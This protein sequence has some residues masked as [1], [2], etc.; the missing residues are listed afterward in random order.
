MLMRA[1]LTVVAGVV[2]LTRMVVGMGHVCDALSG[3]GSEDRA[4]GRAG[5]NGD[6]IV[7]LLVIAIYIKGLIYPVASGPLAGSGRLSSAICTRGVARSAKGGQPSRFGGGL[8]KRCRTRTSHQGRQIRL[9]ACESIGGDEQRG[10][11]VR[12]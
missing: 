8:G 1:A 3:R 11:F 10:I 9:A 2:V 12:E 7:R 5:L 6:V 4:S